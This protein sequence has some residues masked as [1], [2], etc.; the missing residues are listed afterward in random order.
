MRTV[1]VRCVLAA[2]LL[3]GGL[4]EGRT[5]AEQLTPDGLA[6]LQRLLDRARH[7]AL[8]DDVVDAAYSFSF[9]G[10]SSEGAVRFEVR[11]RNGAR[12][13]FLLLDPPRFVP[14]A[15]PRYFVVFPDD[16]I[17][18]SHVARLDAVLDEI[19]TANPWAPPPPTTSAPAGMPPPPTPPGPSAP[20]PVPPWR[21]LAASWFLAATML[22]AVV[23]LAAMQPRE[24]RERLG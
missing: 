11:L 2:A 22:L 21:M 7:G 8:G 18:P 3:A 4:A 12:P 15:V 17:A 24:D 14:G 20:I 16:D 9:K 5:E 1:V 13:G 6:G 10:L 19:F 23:L